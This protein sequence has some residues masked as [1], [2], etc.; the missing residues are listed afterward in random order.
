MLRI[1]GF[2][3]FI[4][5]GYACEIRALFLRKRR[6]RYGLNEKSLE[7]CIKWTRFAKTIRWSSFM[8]DTLLDINFLE[9]HL[10]FRIIG[11]AM[12]VNLKMTYLEF[13]NRKSVVPLCLLAEERSQNATL[14]YRLTQ[15]KTCWFT[16]RLIR[17][18]ACR[19]LPICNCCVWDKA[20]GPFTGERSRL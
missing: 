11:S 4:E 18:N 10:R 9:L 13:L 19:W 12:Q 6:N 16:N 7:Q 8:K 2:H 3:Y 15:K 14:E 20:C 5:L 1:I 17:E